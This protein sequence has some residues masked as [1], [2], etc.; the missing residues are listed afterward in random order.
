MLREAFFALH[1][2]GNKEG[3][4]ARKRGIYEISFFIPSTTHRSLLDRS[5]ATTWRSS[6]STPCKQQA[7]VCGGYGWHR[8]SIN[9]GAC[10]WQSYWW[11]LVRGVTLSSS[12]L[13]P[14]RPRTHTP[15]ASP[16]LVVVVGCCSGGSG[17]L[18]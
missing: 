18:W 13:L 9:S 12:R 8:N 6:H 3:N 11:F 14:P 15:D 7:T 1:K 16:D 4:I 5:R 17:W 2:K 10:G